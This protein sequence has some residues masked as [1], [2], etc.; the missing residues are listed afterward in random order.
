MLTPHGHTLPVAAWR[1][2]GLTGTQG[3]GARYQSLCLSLSVVV[4]LLFLCATD[5]LDEKKLI[6]S[7][8][9]Q[10]AEMILG[11]APLPEPELDE[12]AFAA[13]LQSAMAQVPD[14]YDPHSKMMKPW[15]DLKRLS[16]RRGSCIIT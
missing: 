11:C 13:A 14:V 9:K 1:L 4:Q 8:I 15:I 3:S 2:E 5:L 10:F 16:T 12:K 7:Q 6:P